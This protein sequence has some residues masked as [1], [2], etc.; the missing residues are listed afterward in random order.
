MAA[1]RADSGERARGGERFLPRWV[2]WLALPAAAA[3]F[4]ILAF[5]FLSEGAHDPSRCPFVEVGR[6]KL[7]PSLAVVEHGRR[8]VADVEERRW[9]LA[10]DGRTRVLGNRRLAHAAFAPE[11]YRWAAELSEQ[12][13]VR[14]TVVN[15]GHG[16]VL[17]R[18]GTPEERAR[19]GR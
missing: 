13:E 6:R 8:C 16:Q 15:D 18:E 4:A 10:R 14:V 5:V 7:G 3:P 12:G 1:V 2:L 17:F 19:D 11:R 9:T